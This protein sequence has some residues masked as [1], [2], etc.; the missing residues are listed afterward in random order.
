MFD[1]ADFL[2]LQSAEAARSSPCIHDWANM[3]N[4][5]NGQH[6]GYLCVRCSFQL[7]RKQLM[8]LKDLENHD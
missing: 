3:Y 8:K 7:T 4:L 1:L 2:D 6:V 5:D